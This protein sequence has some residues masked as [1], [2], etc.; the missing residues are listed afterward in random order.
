MIVCGLT[1]AKSSY[2]INHF[3]NEENIE[4]RKI[5]KYELLSKITL[6][7]TLSY[8]SIAILF[9]LI[10]II[11]FKKKRS[12]AVIICFINALVILYIVLNNKELLDE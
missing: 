8:C 1:M 11:Y 10:M 12:I 4:E 6:G 2:E 7:F 3:E 9:A 5:N